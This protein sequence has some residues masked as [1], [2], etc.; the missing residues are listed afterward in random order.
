MFYN[1]LSLND[2]GF[3]QLPKASC[4]ALAL[5]ARSQQ[6]QIPSAS[7]CGQSCK[8]QAPARMFAIAETLRMNKPL[9][10]A[11]IFLWNERET[12]DPLWHHKKRLVMVK[13]C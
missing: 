13:A 6:E 9:Y 5:I 8:E 1:T 10:S 11:R 4:S 7:L 12:G 3:L 2:A